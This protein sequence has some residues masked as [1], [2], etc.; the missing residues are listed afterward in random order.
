MGAALDC[1]MGHSRRGVDRRAGSN[2]GIARTQ[3]PATHR[4]SDVPGT[5]GFTPAKIKDGQLWTL[6]TGHVAPA[7]ISLSRPL[8]DLP[9]GQDVALAVAMSTDLT[10]D[11]RQHLAST[12]RDIPPADRSAMH[13]HVQHKHH[14]LGP[15][16]RNRT[17]HP[18][19]RPHRQ[20]P[21]STSR[22]R[23]TRRIR[24]TPRRNLGP[25]P[26]QPI[27][28]DLAANGYEPAFSIPN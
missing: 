2:P 11:V 3:S 24:R 4:R 1:T 17:R 8:I 9:A 25:S 19:P 16:F 22:P 14:R 18:R 6:P 28:E 20:T 5:A 13:R 12:G 26:H 10:A 15:R 21:G 27:Y 23:H 7:A